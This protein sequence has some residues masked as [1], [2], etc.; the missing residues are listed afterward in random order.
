MRS[1]QAVL[2]IAHGSRLKEGVD[3]AVQFIELNELGGNYIQEICFL[4]LAK[5]TII[6]GI[7]NCIARGATNIAIVPLLL[8]SA[9]HAKKDIPEQIALGMEKY[10]QITFTYGRPFGV[11]EKII[12][13][14]YD[15]I[16]EEG[17]PL[18][19][20]SEV[21]L[22]GRGS[23]DPDVKRDLTKIA[24]QLKATYRLNR[25]N[26]CFLYG[27]TPRFEEV[28]F[29]YV[30]TKPKQV[31]II[32]YLLFT[33]ILMKDITKK[34]QQASDGN[35]ILCESLGYHPNLQQVLTERVYELLLTS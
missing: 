29:E 16:K 24:K 12:D 15:R 26:I 7:E 35:L 21:L 17:V 10:P 25:V 13:A 20:Q 18:T 33:G 8:L 32:P 28:L 34:V 22:V 5:P 11:H 9:V 14:L 4:E 19:A 31:F 2:Y 30:K 27:V 3:E 23:S 1:I 6:E